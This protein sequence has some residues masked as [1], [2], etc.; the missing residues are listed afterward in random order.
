[1]SKIKSF[2][3]DRGQ[4]IR[5]DMFYIKHNSMNFTV[6]DCCLRSDD[7]RRDSIVNEIKSESNGRICRFISTHPHDDHIHGL[8]YLNKRW[9]ITNFYAVENDRTGKDESFKAYLDLKEKHNYPLQKGILRKWL[10]KGDDGRGASGITIYWPV[11]TNVEYKHALG[12][13]QNDPNAISAVIGYRN[14]GLRVLWMGDMETGMQEVMHR[15]IA[16]KIGKVDVLFLPHHGRSSANVPQALLEE[17][18]P[19]LIIVG[20]APFEEIDY[21]HYDSGKTLTQNT[22]LDIQFII[23]KIGLHVY[24]E[25]KINNAPSSLVMQEHPDV[26]DMYYQGSLIRRS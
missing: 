24:T 9:P 17:L 22:A 4:D 7:K 5:G 14:N 3:V 19:R 12:N 26:K 8:D 23:D 25:G 15:E 20:A 10:N 11:V 1:M 13:C 21:A 18:D 6:I 16:G 2:Y